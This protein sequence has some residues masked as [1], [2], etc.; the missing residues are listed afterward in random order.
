MWKA[1]DQGGN[2]YKVTVYKAVQCP[3]G[4]APGQSNDINCK[5]CGG[6]GFFYPLSGRETLAIVTQMRLNRELM[7]LG[8]YEP[9]DMTI[10]P[11]PGSLHLEDWDLVTL[12]W[13]VGIPLQGEVIT[14][15]AGSVDYAS[16]TIARCEGAW[17]VDPATGTN[18]QY[19]QNI[20]FYVNGR[21]IVWTGNNTPATGSVYS[22]RYAAESEWV[23]FNPP[24][25]IIAFGQDLG[26]VCTMRKRA[27]VLQNLR[28]LHEGTVLES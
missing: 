25:P 17:S 18:T 8:M 24:S 3:C 27:I 16:Y 22:I 20:D 4:S 2:A 28:T 26:Q 5:A 23:V 9:G 10:S 19:T 7:D 13:A 11:Q 1:T 15:S 14:R 12:P 21:E 6:L